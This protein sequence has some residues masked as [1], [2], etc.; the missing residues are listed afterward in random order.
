MITETEIEFASEGAVLRGRLVLPSSNA[1]G[2]PAVIMAHGT[3]AT[4]EMVLIEYARE[5]ARAGFVAMVYDHRNFGRSGGEPRCE[6]NPWIQCRDYLSALDF[7]CDRPEIDASRI[8]LWGDS[9]TG[10]HAL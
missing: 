10:G 5:F 3:P 6:I 4:F 2:K 7:A 8:A 9:Y 1:V